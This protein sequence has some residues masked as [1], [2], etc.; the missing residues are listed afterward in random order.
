MNYYPLRWV[1]NRLTRRV[2]SDRDYL[3]GMTFGFA[4]TVLGGIV[5][6][7]SLG[8]ASA[9]G[10]YPSN[11]SPEAQPGTLVCRIDESYVAWQSNGLTHVSRRRGATTITE[12]YADPPPFQAEFQGIEVAVSSDLDVCVSQ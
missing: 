10:H 1:G 5:L 6:L 7:C 9:D 11:P 12:H 3:F 8:C 4:F 2:D